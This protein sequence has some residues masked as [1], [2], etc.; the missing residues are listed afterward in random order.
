MAAT[1]LSSQNAGKTSAS[2]VADAVRLPASTSADDD[3][4]LI[5]R[6]AAKDRQA[7]ETLYYRY[8]RRLYGYVSKFLRQP[9]VVEEVL[10]DTLFVV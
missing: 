1:T 6:M 5:R 3:F 7:F 10:D 8:A 9:E 4:T 2:V